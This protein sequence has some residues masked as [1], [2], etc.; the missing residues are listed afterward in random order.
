[1]TYNKEALI[2]AEGPKP[3]GP[4]SPAVR[5]GSLL[6]L[7]GVIALDP[8]TG[9]LVQDDMEKEISRVMHNIQ[10]VLKEADLSWD[11]VLKVSIFLTNMQHFETVNRVYSQF[12]K[13]PYPARET[14]QVAALPRGARVEI[15]VVAGFPE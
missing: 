6:F 8:A 12:V 7:S 5:F 4:Y 11:H 3:I 14:V 10:A 1:M 13:E 2:P 9:Q 15:S